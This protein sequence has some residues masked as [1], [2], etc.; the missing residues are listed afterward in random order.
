ME[1]SPTPTFHTVPREASPDG[2]P[3]TTET[4]ASMPPRPARSQAWRKWLG[5]IVILLAVAVTVVGL[6]WYTLRPREV[7]LTQATVTTITETIASSGRVRGVTETLVG[8][9]AAGIVQTLYVDEGDRVTAC[10]LL[11]VLKRDVAEVRLAQ[12]ER[13]LDIARAQLAEA[14]SRPLPSEVEAA[15]AQVRQGQAQQSGC[16]RLRHRIGPHRVGAPEIQTSRHPQE[17]GRAPPSAPQGVCPRLE[18]VGLGHRVD[19]HPD[20]MSGGENQRCAIVRALANSPR[21][22]LADEPTGN[23]DSRS[24]QDVFALMREMS[25]ESSVAFVM[26]TH[27]DCLAQAADRI[28]LIEDGR[29]RELSKD[30]RR[31]RA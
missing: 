8:A 13:A 15:A 12:A 29:I 5:W 19:N 14:E 30:G 20:A 1:S 4:S 7:S 10:R 2:H 18:R 27:D 16:F 3:D 11:A 21:I 25:R 6:R 24:G 23:I 9:Q 22:V 28:L 26:V 31:P 17:H